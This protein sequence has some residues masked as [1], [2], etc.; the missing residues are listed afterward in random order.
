MGVTDEVKVLCGERS[1]EPLAKRK[2][3]PRGQARKQ[4]GAKPRVDEQQADRG[5]ADRSEGPKDPEALTTKGLVPYIRRLRG[6][7]QRSYLGRSRLVPERATQAP[8]RD[9][10]REVSR[11]HSSERW[12][13]DAGEEPVSK[14]ARRAERKGERDDREPRR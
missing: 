8:R 1:S 13:K 11:G 14:A 6:E 2:G 12:K 9:A 10:E 4:R 3:S 7:S 5:G